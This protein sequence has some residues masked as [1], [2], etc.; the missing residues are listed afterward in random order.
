MIWLIGTFL[1]DHVLA[2]VVVVP[3][4]ERML[5]EEKTL[6]SQRSWRTLSYRKQGHPRR[7]RRCWPIW[8]AL[9]SWHPSPSA[10]GAPPRTPSPPLRTRRCVRWWRS[11]APSC[12]SASATRTPWCGC[13]PSP[14]CSPAGA[15]LLGGESR[16]RGD[17]TFACT[18]LRPRRSQLPRGGALFLRW[19]LW[20]G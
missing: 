2:V 20:W 1:H 15:S 10:C 18:P 3:L 11:G 17:V 5:R 13:N 6:Q 19:P 14:R 12:A 9:W 16:P 7:S 8:R 4:G